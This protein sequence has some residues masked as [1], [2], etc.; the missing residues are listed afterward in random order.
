MSHISTINST[1]AVPY[2]STIIITDVSTDA[3]SN[4]ATTIRSYEPTISTT[5]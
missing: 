3:A 1:F 2:V 4:D 5:D